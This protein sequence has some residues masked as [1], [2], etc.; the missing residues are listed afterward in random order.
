MTRLFYEKCKGYYLH[1]VRLFGSGEKVGGPLANVRESPQLRGFSCSSDCTGTLPYGAN[2]GKAK[3]GT[4]E[5]S[6][7][8]TIRQ[9]CCDPR[10]AGS[11]TQFQELLFGYQPWISL[12]LR[13]CWSL[14]HKGRG[15]RSREQGPDD[16]E[17]DGRTSRYPSGR[18]LYCF[19]VRVYEGLGVIGG[20]S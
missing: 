3:E 20:K 1:S 18:Q 4:E 14:A 19:R 8:R 17:C 11:Q 9:R 2:K 13:G 12:L 7:S 5:G 6:S 15:S 16:Y 10:G